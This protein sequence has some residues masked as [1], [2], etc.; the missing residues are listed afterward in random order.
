MALARFLQI[1]DVHLGRS[2]AWLPPDRREAR[3]R[4]Q[5]AALEQC[6]RHAIER[7]AHAILVPGD[8]FDSVPVEAGALPYAAPAFAVS[9]CP[10][11]FIA[12]GNHDPVASDSAAWSARLQQARG[13]PWPPHVHVF[14]SPAW[15]SAPL[16]GQPAV[17][18][19]GRAFSGGSDTLDR[20]LA[21]AALEG[22]FTPGSD[23]LDIAVFHGSREG[24]CP[25]GQ[26]ITAAFSD[27]EV[28]DS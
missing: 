13:T 22:A 27:D 12:P 9:G 8:L 14:E 4:D 11:G 16:P 28:D 25:P 5:Q 6:V 24:R 18:V 20:P 15:T 3:R 7:G 26:K 1:S 10:P 2:F 21:K 23:T 19:W 17:R